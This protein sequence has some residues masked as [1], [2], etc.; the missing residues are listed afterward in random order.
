MTIFRFANQRR[1]YAASISQVGAEDTRGVRSGGPSQMIQPLQAYSMRFDGQIL[2]RGF[3]LYVIS[4]TAPDG[5]HLY[6]GRTG[7][8]S[9]PNAASPFSRIGSHL[10]F[11]PSAKGNALIKNL[12]EAGI[13]P[14]SC[15]FEMIAIGPVY[16]EQ[17]DF[18]RHKP[19]RDE[20]GALEYGLAQAL[21]SRGHSVLGNHSSS[22]STKPAVL[23]EVL[24]LVEGFLG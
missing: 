10:D 24:S 21:R 6:V 13:D 4:I 16:P 12:S 22:L 3:W 7:D 19:L 17:T 5:R 15:R 1:A 23:S 8:S 14:A 20:V 11:R 9:S 2:C 18:E